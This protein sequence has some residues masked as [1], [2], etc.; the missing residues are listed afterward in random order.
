VVHGNRETVDAFLAASRVL[1]GVAAASL[2]DV[3]DITLP[4]FRALV[5]L[6]SRGPT[7][8]GELAEALDVHPSTATRLCDRLERKDLIGRARPDGDRRTTEVVLAEAGRRVVD[9]VT[10]RRRR[11]ISRVVDR[12]PPGQRHAAIAALEAFAG[13]AAEPSAADAWGWSPAEPSARG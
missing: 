2:A 7:T 1:V 8:V 3:D 12:M 10:E 5:V 13:A 11:A 4:Q 6:S 9:R